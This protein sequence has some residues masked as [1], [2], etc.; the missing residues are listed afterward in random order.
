[1]KRSFFPYL[2]I[3]K[4]YHTFALKYLIVPTNHYYTFNKEK[5][6]LVPI[7]DVLQCTKKNKTVPSD[8]THNNKKEIVLYFRVKSSIAQ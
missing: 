6:L 8:N 5:Y 2:S 3:C 7:K 4:R 1:M